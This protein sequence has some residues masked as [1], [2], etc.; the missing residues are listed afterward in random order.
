MSQNEKDST[1]KPPLDRD[2]TREP[3]WIWMLK[4]KVKKILSTKKVVCQDQQCT[5]TSRPQ[6]ST[7]STRFFPKQL[8]EAQRGKFYIWMPK[9]KTQN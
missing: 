4:A 8:V 1:T 5:K 9:V 6:S 7:S 2:I 3:Q